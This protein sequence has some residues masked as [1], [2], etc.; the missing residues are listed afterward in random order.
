MPLS[1]GQIWKAIDGLARREGISAG[2][3]GPN[4]RFGSAYRTGI[5]IST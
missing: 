1:H 3:D 2:S 4:G 5:G